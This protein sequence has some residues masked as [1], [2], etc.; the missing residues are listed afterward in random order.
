MVCKGKWYSRVGDFC[1]VQVAVTAEC[2]GSHIAVFVATYLA[3][4]PCVMSGTS[5]MI[6]RLTISGTERSSLSGWFVR[7]NV[8]FVS[9]T[10][11]TDPVRS[12]PSRK[13]W[14]KS[15]CTMTLS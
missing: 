4:D 5:H 6:L 14:D 12:L 2:G 8:L 9:M 7:Y 11:A 3:S 10:F 1:N 13:S 15:G